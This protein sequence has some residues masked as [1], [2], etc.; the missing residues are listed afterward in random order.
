MV[1]FHYTL[2]KNR[3]HY[4]IY[5]RSISGL[6]LLLLS[7][8][9]PEIPTDVIGLY[10]DINTKQIVKKGAIR[11]VSERLARYD[12][13]KEAKEHL[14]KLNQ[15]DEFE[16]VQKVWHLNI[17]PI[18]KEFT[19]A[20]LQ[21]YQLYPEFLKGSKQFTTQDK[22]RVENTAIRYSEQNVESIIKKSVGRNELL[23]SN[24]YNDLRHIIEEIKQ[25]GK[26]GKLSGFTAEIKD[27]SDSF[28]NRITSRRKRTTTNKFWE[29]R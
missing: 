3:K 9:L 13:E 21:S 11:V 28:K 2:T 27:Q 16:A 26:Q 1:N 7:P 12:T 20:K 6:A 24:A 8:R 22:I 19:A 25:P 14:R 15:L 23:T 29:K 10:S 5:V 17:K 4:G 18:D